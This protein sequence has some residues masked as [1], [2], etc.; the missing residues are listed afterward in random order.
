MKPSFHH[1]L[2]NGPFEDPALYV[3]LLW[4]SRALLFDAGTVHRLSQGDLHRI[5][6]IFITHTHIDHFIGF[7][8]VLRSLLRRQR[9]LN[10]Y[11][12]SNI[13]DCIEGKL[14]GYAWNLIKD[15]PLEVEVY[16]IEG[17]LIRHSSFHAQNSFGRVH[18]DDIPFSGVALR[19]A[20][21]AVKAAAF[22]HDIQCIGYAI[23]EDFHINIDKAALSAL[24]LPVGPWLS[25]LKKAIR[26][27]APDDRE[28]VIDGR[29]WSL[30]R[31]R[32]ITAITKGQKLSY[33]MDIAP[34]GE[35]IARAVE[36]ARNSDTLYCEA[37]FLDADGERALER[38]HLTA[39]LAGT[40]A[41][42]ANVRNLVITHFSPKYKGAPD[43]L[44]EEARNYSSP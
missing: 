16:G 5:T 1:R 13:I 32:E 11:G 6:D 33:I 22:T 43:A 12:P 38:N 21:F 24:G 29:P 18:R 40:I 42:E 34:T 39:R 3:R 36:L 8:S 7:D 14:K 27:A 2:V 10:V 41:R 17:S 28:F 19:E 31:L 20:F 9:P 30:G 35:N 4:E 15:Y 23:E 26:G 25:E 44:I 37:Y